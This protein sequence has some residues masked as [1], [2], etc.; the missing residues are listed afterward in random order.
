M[1][2]IKF[3][4]LFSGAGGGS[5]GFIDAGF[6]ASGAVDNNPNLSET[7]YKNNGIEPMICERLEKAL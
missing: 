7:Y 5:R 6:S 1:D 4:E 2:R 3:I